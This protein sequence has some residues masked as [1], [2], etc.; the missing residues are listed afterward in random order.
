MLPEV[1]TIAGLHALYRNGAS[2]ADVL[3]DV[4]AR[5]AACP[6][7]AIWISLRPLDELLAEA[8]SLGE[9]PSADKPL[10]GAPFAVKDN[11]DCAGLPTTAA[12][13]AFAYTPA[14]DAFA[15]ARLRAAGAILIGK[16]N[17]DQ[18]ATGLNGTRSP[19]GA[20]RCVFNA[21]YVSGGSSS[22]S[23]VAVGAGQ[24]AFSLGTD[25]AGSGRVPAA[26]N[27]LVGVKPTKG[28]VSTTGLVP[29]CRS[30]DCIT[31]LAGTVGEADTVR[32]LMQ[33]FDAAD[34]FSRAMQPR[35]LP[36]AG[37]RFGVL[38]A[39]EREFFGDAETAALYDAAAA[40]LEALGA[41]RV[42]I[43]Y[44]PF[45]ECAALLYGGPWVAERLAAIDT[46]FD[47]HA[48]DME[49]AVRDIVAGARGMSAVDAFKGVYV[50]EAYR[51]RADVEWAKMDVLLLPTAPT[52]YKVADMQADPIRLNSNLGR[53]TN[54][55]NLLD[56][57][58]VA[59][60]AGFR[61]DGLP[62]G[63]TLIAPAFADDALAAL[64]DRLHRAQHFGMGRDRAAALAGEAMRAGDDGL[65][66]IA[67]V[68]AHLTGMPLNHQLT[69]RDGILLRKTRTA[70][71]YRLFALPNTTPP[72]P[73]LMNEPG[74]AGPG[75]DIEI[76][77]LTPKHF[78]DFVESIPAPMGIG[79]LKLADGGEVSGFIC[80][81]YAFHGAQDITEF[82]GW[83]AFVASRKG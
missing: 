78:G 33:G 71:D 49:P 27:N 66:E 75:L 43:D 14:A 17:L 32:R 34:A 62:G 7:K 1:L 35:A 64:A 41:T 18:F 74:F 20:P 25:T 3:R 67:V 8:A 54:F 22:G 76:W 19:Y 11:I 51:R 21:D 28:L 80:E 79:K 13:P 53:Y 82:G 50:L 30:L 52:I 12:C 72:K 15:V 37:L 56:C 70:A 4:M 44:A 6:D 46:F 45:R 9:G 24:V 57:S 5:I 26:F 39:A 31:V 81:P 73:G 69:S 10:W 48:N 38:G 29:A 40:R 61:V 36:Q 55:V 77:G 2:P 23:A 68:G 65:L 42:E 47:A 16:T 58:A 83:R 60:P 59:I 63:V